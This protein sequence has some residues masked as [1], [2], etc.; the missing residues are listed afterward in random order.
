MPNGFD[1]SRDEWNRLEAQLLEWDGTLQDFAQA[2]GLQLVKN[3]HAWPSRSLEA[4]DPPLQRKVELM[5]KDE[6][7]GTF[8]VWAYAWKDV[9]GKRFLKMSPIRKNAPAAELSGS[10]P[11]ILRDAWR[12]ARA[13]SDRDLE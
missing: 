9:G 4:G 1:G 7:P 3:A 2:H 11:E 8:S 5:A 10:L 13:W 6:P 12:M